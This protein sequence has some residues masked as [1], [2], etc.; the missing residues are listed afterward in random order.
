MKMLFKL[1]KR[2]LEKVRYSATFKSLVSALLFNQSFKRIFVFRM[3]KKYAFFTLL[4]RLLSTRYA[5]HIS[6]TAEIGSGFC[7][8]HCFSIIISKCIIGDDVTVM[9]QVTIGSRGGGRN[10]YPK[11][12]SRVF[13]GA[14]AK[15][16]GNVTIG[17]DVVI[18]ANAVVTKDIPSG[19]VVGGIPAKVLS[20]EGKQQSVLWCSDIKFMTNYNKNKC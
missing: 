13:V 3:S 10:G 7:I 20:M 5:V 12:G 18:G 9:Q 2:D 11:I 4:D 1:I 16:L 17:D 8:G 14:G 6:K 19:A 15:I